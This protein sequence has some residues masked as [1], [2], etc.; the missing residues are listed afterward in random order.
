MILC[1]K[2][3]SDN[4]FKTRTMIMKEENKLIKIVEQKA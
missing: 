3:E 1:T 4:E 2:I